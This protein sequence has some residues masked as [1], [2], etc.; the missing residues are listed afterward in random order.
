MEGMS[1]KRPSRGAGT[2]G[3]VAY[4]PESFGSTGYSVRPVVVDRGSGPIISL[5]IG[6]VGRALPSLVLAL[7][8]VL[9]NLAFASL[10][11]ALSGVV[12]RNNFGLLS[13]M[14][15][16]PGILLVLGIAGLDLFGYIAHF[17][18][19]K[20]SAGWRFH[21]VHHSELEVDVTTAF[22]QHPGET[23]WR[24]LWQGLGI[25]VFELPFWIVPL[26]LSI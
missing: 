3:V 10:M 7:G 12:V 22:R 6:K 15:L 2:H 21:R 16:H 25:T 17:L 18:L 14:R 24:V 11:A 13:G 4:R 1:T 26:Y 23:I 20:M 5:S 19:H 9:V 8:V